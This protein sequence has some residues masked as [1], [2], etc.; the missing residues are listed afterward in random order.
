MTIM[1]TGTIMGIRTKTMITPMRVAAKVTAA[2]RME[3]MLTEDMLTEDMGTAMPRPISIR[4]SLS[5]SR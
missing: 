2:T 1:M 5:G 4:P 3:G